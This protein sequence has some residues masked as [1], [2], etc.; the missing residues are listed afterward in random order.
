MNTEIIRPDGDLKREVWNFSIV[1]D[2]SGRNSITLQYYSFQ[3]KETKRH[4]W[5]AQTHWTRY[6]RRSNNID[7]PPIP[8]DVDKEIHGIYQK[9]ISTLPITL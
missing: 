3:T 5:K 6:D 8:L 1:I 7:I 4:K 2:H 9:F